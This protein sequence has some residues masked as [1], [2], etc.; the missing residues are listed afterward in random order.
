ML[1]ACL[2]FGEY[3]TCTLCLFDLDEVSNAIKFTTK[4][5]VLVQC[6]IDVGADDV[7]PSS[8]RLRF[9][10]TFRLHKS[11]CSACSSSLLCQ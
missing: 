2:V 9:Q 7:P 5:K 3:I 10:V 6:D 1:R 8:L 4:G 11:L